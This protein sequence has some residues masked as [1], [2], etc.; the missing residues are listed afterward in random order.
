MIEQE[1]TGYGTTPVGC[2]G[3]SRYVD[4]FMVLWLYGFLVFWCYGFLVS[5]ICQISI[6]CF[7]EGIDL[8]S[9]LF[10]ILLNGFPSFVG[11]R[12]F[13]TWSNISKLWISQTFI[14]IKNKCSHSFLYRSTYFGVFKSINK[15]SPGLTNPEIMEFGGFGP[16]HKTEILL[17][18][19]EAE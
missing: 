12:L 6:S 9:K 3:G 1:S 18:Q 4:C 5:T 15:C 2:R 19:N 10:E 7:Q 17:E 8:I 14:F 13:Q 11:A 16:S